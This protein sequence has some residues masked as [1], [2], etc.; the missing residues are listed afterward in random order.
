MRSVVAA[1]ILSVLWR[2]APAPS[3][4]MTPQLIQDVQVFDGERV[5]QHRSVLIENGKISRIPAASFKLA[6]ATLVDG[7]GKTLLAGLF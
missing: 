5:L 6:G 3:Q 1:L 2:A 4:T 7:R